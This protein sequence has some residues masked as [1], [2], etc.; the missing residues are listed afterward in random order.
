L[1][2]AIRAQGNA[3]EYV[4]ISLILLVL[5]ELDG[6][7]LAFIHV[8]GIALIMGRLIHAKGLLTDNLPYRILGMQ[9]TL[10][11]I[12]TLALLNIVYAGMKAFGG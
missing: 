4:P 10:F 1:E 11:T 6:A 3:T 5:L 7:N 12:I 8:G 2:G 9:F